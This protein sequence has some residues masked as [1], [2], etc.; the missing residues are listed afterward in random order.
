MAR[1]LSGQPTGEQH[2]ERRAGVVEMGGMKQKALL[3]ERRLQ[4]WNKYE[5]AYRY[6]YTGWRRVHGV[7]ATS[8]ACEGDETRIRGGRGKL[9]AYASPHVRLLSQLGRP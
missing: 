5:N 9:W 8:E 6:R 3:H 2:A 1:N 7:S 4:R